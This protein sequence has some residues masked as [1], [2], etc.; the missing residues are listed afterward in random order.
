MDHAPFHGA[1]A[2]SL[3][4]RQTLAMLNQIRL[5]V[6]GALLQHE[7]RETLS[8]DFT[9]CEDDGDRAKKGSDPCMYV[10]LHRA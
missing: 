6:P 10:C 8:E 1:G 2:I 3:P 5:S 7:T 9:R 4:P